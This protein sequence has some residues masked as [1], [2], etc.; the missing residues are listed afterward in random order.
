[1][2][3]KELIKLIKTELRIAHLT[4][5]GNSFLDVNQAIIHESELEDRR[6]NDR[7]WEQ[8]KERIAEIVLAV[9]NKNRWGIYFK[10]DPMQTL[11]MKDSSTSLFRVN[12]VKQDEFID[13]IK[14]HMDEETQERKDECQESQT[15][16]ASQ[17]DKES[18]HGT[19]RTL[20]DTEE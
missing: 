14:G 13:T 20:N 5:D 3:K 2:S 16:N 7:R 17:I 9:L 10:S 1:M 19:E 4:T 6:K 8:M 18:S 12:E 15:Q 11:P